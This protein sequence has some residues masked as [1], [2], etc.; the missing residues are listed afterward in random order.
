MSKL[1]TELV[2]RLV[3]GHKRRGVEVARS[4]KPVSR[5]ESVAAFVPLQIEAAKAEPN[6]AP[7]AMLR[8][9]VCTYA[10]PTGWSSISAKLVSTSCHQQCEEPIPRIVERVG[11]ARG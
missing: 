1:N 3:T 5:L 6:R 11:D 10:W 7:E 8:C 4:I 9:C 2:S